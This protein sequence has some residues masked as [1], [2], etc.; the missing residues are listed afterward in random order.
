MPL[1][2]RGPGVA[3][4]CGGRYSTVADATP[5]L[6]GGA[7][8]LIVAGAGALVVARRRRT[9]GSTDDGSAES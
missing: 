5:W 8:V 3:R 1:A 6:I 2:R 4:D 7:G 9:D